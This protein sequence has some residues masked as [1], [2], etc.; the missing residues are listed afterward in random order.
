M[1]PVIS[2]YQILQKKVR[3]ADWIQAHTWGFRNV[4]TF[5]QEAKLLMYHCRESGAGVYWALEQE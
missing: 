2:G 3:G 4:F 1:W 5:V